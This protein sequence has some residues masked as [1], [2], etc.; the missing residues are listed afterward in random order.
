VA[1]VGDG[2]SRTLTWP[3]GWRWIGGAAPGSLAANKIGWLEL[4]STTTADT[5]V[6]AQWSVE[7]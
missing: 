3:A 1:L 7:P 6:L 2:S 4:L 5:G